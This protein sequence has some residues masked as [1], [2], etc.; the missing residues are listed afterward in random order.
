MKLLILILVLATSAQPLQAGFCDM[1]MEKNQET[2]HH[3]YPDGQV[4]S[5]SLPGL[6]YW[7]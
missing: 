3:I 2:S 7:Q 1:D 6:R 4:F 5:E